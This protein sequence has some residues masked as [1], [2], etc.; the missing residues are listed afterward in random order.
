MKGLLLVFFVLTV[1]ATPMPSCQGAESCLSCRLRGQHKLGIG[2]KN[3]EEHAA[4]NH[5]L[6]L[7]H[8][9]Q[10]QQLKTLL[11]QPQVPKLT[12]A[13]QLQQ[14]AAPQSMTLE[15]FQKQQKERQQPQQ[16]QQQQELQQQTAP[17]EQAG[18]LRSLPAWLPEWLVSPKSGGGTTS[19]STT[20]TTTTAVS[21]T[22]DV[23]NEIPGVAIAA[24]AV[25]TL[26]TLFFKVASHTTTTTAPPTTHADGSQQTAI[27][28]LSLLPVLPSIPDESL[29]NDPESADTQNMPAVTEGAQAIAASIP[30]E[31][32]NEVP[33]HPDSYSYSGLLQQDTSP[34]S[35]IRRLIDLPL[36]TAA[37]SREYQY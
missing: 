20:T 23:K 3:H 6:Q 4:L 25:P 26:G 31:Q 8:Q 37:G 14:Q 7:L 1:L 15:Q 27:D 32:H 22:A 12:S 17:R 10:Q 16:Q 18:G 24:P 9:Q 35:G 2:S 29:L 11:S 33:L 36:P 19:I 21:T 5:Q 13:E 28:A 34:I 30:L